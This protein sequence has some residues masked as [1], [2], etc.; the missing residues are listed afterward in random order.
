[1][2]IAVS[3]KGGVG[4][5]TIAALLAVQYAARGRS[6]LAVD[7]DIDA[8][9][10]E[11]LGF[12]PDELRSLEP[13]SGMRDLI[14]ERTGAEP[15]VPGQI[16]ALNPRV[17]DIPDAYSL[18]R[19]G[20][21]LLR[22]GAVKAAGK[23]C[24]CP[25]NALLKALL[26]HLVVQRNETVVVDLEAGLEHLGR[27]TAAAVDAMLVVI[28]PGRRSF[29]TAADIASLCRALGVEKTYAVANKVRPEEE[30]QV[31]AGVPAGVPLLAVLPYDPSAVRCDLEGRPPHEACPR[32]SSAVSALARRL[33]ELAG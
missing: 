30:E 26:R 17:D 16:F 6:V 9:L 15:G 7:A 1:V 2:K 10:G 28:E 4:K 23:G 12:A 19:N 25:E 22:M 31:R 18:A 20:V 11:A 3:G 32:L 27:G 33:E 21:R 5:T 29:R 24:A 8:N 14:R 13:I